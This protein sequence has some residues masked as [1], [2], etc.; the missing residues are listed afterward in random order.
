MIVLWPSLIP[1]LSKSYDNIT[2]SKVESL[3]GDVDEITTHF[4]FATDGL[5]IKSTE[6]A[7]KTIKLDNDSLDFLD[8]GNKVAQ[9][10]DQQLSITN[11]DVLNE[12]K[13]GSIKLKPSGRGGILFVFEE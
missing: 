6:N 10:S 4:S 7:S 1:S 8:N 12:L 2:A 9:I 11:A 3:G 13:I 5:T